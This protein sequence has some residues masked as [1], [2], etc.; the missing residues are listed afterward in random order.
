MKRQR[1]AFPGSLPPSIISAKELNFCVRYGYR[2]DLLAIVTASCSSFA[3]YAAFLLA[4]SKVTYPLYAPFSLAPAPCLSRKILRIPYS[5]S[6]RLH[7]Q[8]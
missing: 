2:Y 7:T 6:E 4:R 8:N 5:L 1:L 3:P